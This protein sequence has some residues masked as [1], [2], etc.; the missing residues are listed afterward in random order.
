MIEMKKETI[1]NIL[2]IAQFVI[3]CFAVYI[4]WSAYNYQAG[5]YAGIEAAKAAYVPCN[6]VIGG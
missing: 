1:N 5:Y 6:Y 3:L 4:A 2:I